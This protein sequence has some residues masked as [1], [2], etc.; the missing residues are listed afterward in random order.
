[1]T[2]IIELGNSNNWDLIW[3]QSYTAFTNNFGRFIPIPE[4]TVPLLFDNHVLAIR[5][6]TEIPEGSN[7]YFGGFL[8]QK[9]QLGAVVGGGLDASTIAARRLR[10][11]QIQLILLEKLTSTFG[12]NIAVPKWFNDATITLWEY[13]GVDLDKAEVGIER[14]EQKIDLLLTDREIGDADLI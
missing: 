7:W 4:I 12:I 10:L 11:G 9:F 8:Y 6:D 5:I 2:R 1:M 13:T 3:S 14:V